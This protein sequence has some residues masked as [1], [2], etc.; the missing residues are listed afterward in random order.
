MNESASSMP[1]YMPRMLGAARP[2]PPYAPSTWNHAPSS[3]HTSATEARSSMIPKFVVPAVAT[4]ANN[5]STPA[6]RAVRR[7]F[8]PVS[9]PCSSTGTP[10]KS[11]SMT[12]HAL[13]T[14]EC[15]WVVPATAHRRGSSPARRER[16]VCR[17][18]TSA[19]RLPIVPP[20]TNTPPAVSG[21]PAR[22]A[23]QRRAAF[24]A[25]TAPAPSSQLPAY[26]AEAPT[27]R[28]NSVLASV[29]AQGMNDRNRGWS[30]EMHAGASSVVNR[31]SAAAPPSPVAVMVAPATSSSSA[32]VRGPSRGTGSIRSRRRA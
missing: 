11:T 31:S 18:A 32:G 12:S 9:R 17:A 22:S 5:P 24:S 6:A 8:S 25:W 28:S 16:A 10:R 7:R 30:V 4:T 2:A 21:R 15:A 20:G 27:T 13:L 26:S 14:E 1:S 3:A 19:D 23:T 29:G